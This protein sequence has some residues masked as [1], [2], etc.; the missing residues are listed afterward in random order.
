VAETIHPVA[1][2]GA[3]PGD[4]DL[5]TLKALRLIR[6]ADV[7]VYDR[8]VS[9]PILALIP[10]GT[11]RIFAGKIA[12]NHHVPQAAINALL[13]GL[14]RSGRKVVR[15]KGGDPFLFGRGGEEAECLAAH[16]IAFEIVPGVT[17]ASGCTAYAGIPLTHRG[18]A[19]GVRFVTGHAKEDIDLN[20]DWRALADPDTTLVLYM[21]R[22]HVERIADE[23]IRHGLARATPAA[24]IVNGT[25]PDQ[26]TLIT[27]LDELPARVADLD[28]AAPTLIVIGRVVALAERLAWFNPERDVP[29]SSRAG[30]RSES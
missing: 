3:G 28:M 25:R 12:R 13:V 14:A 29:S 5:L 23:L 4:P 1:L 11:S 9:P 20:L 24:I 8:L 27:T 19:H 16:G 6:E 26:L 2:V 7:V 15:L 10:V 22:I 30:G 18:L 21:G 17:S